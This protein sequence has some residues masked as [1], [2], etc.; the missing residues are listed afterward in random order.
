MDPLS[1]DHSVAQPHWDDL[2]GISEGKAIEDNVFAQVVLN[3]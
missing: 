3:R 2:T 1:V